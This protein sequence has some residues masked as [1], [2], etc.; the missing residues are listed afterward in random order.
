MCFL[1]DMQSM[2]SN[3]KRIMDYAREKAEEIFDSFLH[4]DLA[5]R[6]LW[7]KFHLDKSVLRWVSKE[8]NKFAHT[9]YC[10]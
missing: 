5:T 1:V 4:D 3:G 6:T 10:G 9:L 2:S 8:G 7:F